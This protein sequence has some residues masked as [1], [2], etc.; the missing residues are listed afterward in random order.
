M[1]GIQRVGYTPPPECIMLVV[2][3][4][5]ENVKERALML[6]TNLTRR[7]VSSRTLDNL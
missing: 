7:F 6:L 1:E 2:L 4:Q 5:F 3:Q